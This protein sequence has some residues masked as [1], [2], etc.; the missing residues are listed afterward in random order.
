MRIIIAFLLMT[1]LASASP[2]LVCDPQPGVAAYDIIVGGAVV[3]SDYPAEADGSIHYDI[4]AY[5]DGGQYQ[6][7]LIAVDASGWRSDSSDPLD[8]RKPTKSGNVRIEE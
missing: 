4:A 1:G 6:F 8:A 3:E 7:M 2:F 5:A